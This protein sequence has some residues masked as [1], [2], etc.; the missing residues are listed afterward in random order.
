M[1]PKVLSISAT[2]KAL[3]TGGLSESY[4][5]T[6][7]RN[8]TGEVELKVQAYLTVVN[9]KLPMLKS[10]LRIVAVYCFGVLR[11]LKLVIYSSVVGLMR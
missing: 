11:V 7:E 1:K 6:Q 8:R 2:F 10:C 4:N 5:R 3:L 9:V